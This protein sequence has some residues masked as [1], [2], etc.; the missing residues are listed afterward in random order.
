MS[1]YQLLGVDENADAKSIRKVWQKLSLELHPDKTGG[2]KEKEKKLQAINNAYNILKNESTRDEYDKQNGFGK[3]RKS[4]SSSSSAAASSSSTSTAIVV[5]QPTSTTVS[6]PSKS[7][8]TTNTTNTASAIATAATNT[9]TTGSAFNK[10]ELATAAIQQAPNMINGIASLVSGIIN[11]DNNAKIARREQDR[12]DRQLK[13]EEE[14]ADKEYKLGLE[15]LKL[16]KEQEEKK[17]EQEMEKIKQENKEKAIKLLDSRIKS[18]SD[19]NDSLKDE[20]TKLKQELEQTEQDLKIVIENIDTFNK[21][22]EEKL[23][24]IKREI[25]KI[26]EK[27]ESNNE[28][29]KDAISKT[30]VDENNISEFLILINDGLLP[31]TLINQQESDKL[32]IKLQVFG[33]IM[34]SEC[35][36]QLTIKRYFDYPG[37]KLNRLVDILSEQGFNECIELDVGPDD[38]DEF[39]LNPVTQ[40]LEEKLKLEPEN[41]EYNKLLPREKLILKKCCI[42]DENNN[43]IPKWEKDV[44]DKL[45]ISKTKLLENSPLFASFFNKMDE[46]IIDANKLLTITSEKQLNIAQQKAI[47]MR[48]ENKKKY[49]EI[50]LKQDEEFKDV[51]EDNK[52]DDV[53]KDNENEEEVK[54]DD[55]NNNNNNNNKQLTPL[56]ELNRDAD[57]LQIAAI[58]KLHVVESMNNEFEPK[59]NDNIRIIRATAKTSAIHVENCCLQIMDTQSIIRKTVLLAMKLLEFKPAKPTN[60]AK[61]LWDAIDSGIGQIFKNSI[62]MNKISAEYFGYFKK[63]E[64]AF[65]TFLSSLQIKE[66]TSL[67]TALDPVTQQIDKFSEFSKNIEKTVNILRDSAIK[68]IENCV[69]QTQGAKAFETAQRERKTAEQEWRRLKKEYNLE[70]FKTSD[71]YE[72]LRIEKAKLTASKVSNEYNFNVN[73]DKINSNKIYIDDYR[74]KMN[75]KMSQ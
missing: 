49:K 55:D 7:S 8:T 68:T 67:I 24:L 35:E 28:K 73:K 46:A 70:Q 36:S 29:I 69:K 17:H 26:W 6:V 22:K 16:Q 15:K 10:T 42:R 39:I 43:K 37:I 61:P 66:D 11:A 41:K 34:K 38:Y 75:E 45:L 50:K 72:K 9:T 48:K 27:Y 57:A 40:S 12:L 4:S 3:Y 21:E 53:A 32:V 56:E 1:Y 20:Q 25:D 58:V 47:E 59:D 63:F 19:E 65:K 5:K 51:N 71:Q 31:A 18:L 14:K 52:E 2:D 60:D 30:N 13:L 64:H 23:K 74:K 62:E 54:D 33:D 44:K